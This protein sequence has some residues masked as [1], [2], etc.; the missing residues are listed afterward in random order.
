M[1]FRSLKDKEKEKELAAAKPADGKGQ[2]PGTTATTPQGQTINIVINNTQAN[3]QTQQTTQTVSQ[4][5]SQAQNQA[6]AQGAAPAAAAPPQLLYQSDKMVFQA[7]E[8]AV[9]STAGTIIRDFTGTWGW[10]PGAQKQAR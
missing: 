2:A 4:N 10:Q 6:Q 5:Q 1:L 8:Q 9:G 3:T 7:R